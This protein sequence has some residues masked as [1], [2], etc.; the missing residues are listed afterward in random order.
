[1]VGELIDQGTH[2][3]DMHKLHANFHQ[4]D[5]E[6]ILQ[7]P[8]SYRSAGED[9][10]AWAHEQ[11]GIYKVKSSYHMLVSNVDEQRV[12]GTAVQM[13]KWIFGNVYGV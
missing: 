6:R 2:Q 12:G 7:I 13:V 10:I 8:L 5:V 3:W 11:S 9:W 4:I 1:M